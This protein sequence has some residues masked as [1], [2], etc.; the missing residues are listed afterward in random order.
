MEGDARGD[1]AEGSKEAQVSVSH[2]NLMT[3]LESLGGKLNGLVSK[4]LIQ[5]GGP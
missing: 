2:S 1:V 5:M 4:E 3:M